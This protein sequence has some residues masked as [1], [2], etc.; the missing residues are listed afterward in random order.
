VLRTTRAIPYLLALVVGVVVVGWLIPVADVV[1]AHPFDRAFDGDRAASVIGQR[2]F[3][4]APWH[5][6]L[7]LA[8]RLGWPSG[9][10]VAFT[11]SIPLALLPLKLIAGWLPHGFYVQEGWLALAW[12]LQPVAAVFALRGTG[13]RRVT[14]CLA[15][16]VLSLCMPAL[17]SRYGSMALCTHAIILGAIGLYF[18]LAANPGPRLWCGAWLLLLAGLLVHP[19]LLVM[20]AA[21]LGAVP[22]TL[23]LRGDQSWRAAACWLFAAAVLTGGAGMVLGYGG[24]IPAEGFGR[25]SMNLLSPFVPTVPGLFGYHSPDPTGGQVDEGN[26][27]LGSGVLLLCFIGLVQVLRGRPVAIR[28][29]LGLVV[30]LGILTVFSLSNRVYAGSYLLLQ[31]NSVP[32]A[33]QQFRATGR[34]FWPAAYVLLI[35]GV[36]VTARTL[37]PRTALLVFL[38][39]IGLQVAETWSYRNAIWYSARVF[40]IWQIDPVQLRPILARHDLLTIW[41]SFNCGA[42]TSGGDARFMQLL[43]LASETTMRTN[44]MYVARTSSALDCDAASTLG[45]PWRPHEV[46]AILPP[47]NPGDR[48]LV[49]D[50][51]KACRT[52]GALVL[53]APD[54]PDVQALPTA[55]APEVPLGSLVPSGSALGRAMLGEGWSVAGNDGVW[56]D[57][58][59]AA[60]RFRLPPGSPATVAI[61]LQAHAIAAGASEHQTVRLL[62]NG[63]A[64]AVWSIPEFTAATLQAVIPVYD[65]MV[66]ELQVQQPVRPA[67]R[68]LNMDR[69]L[70]GVHLNAV[71]M[72]PA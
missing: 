5:W 37:R 41:P 42:P 2:Y 35:A 6:P 67:D 28:R 53:C 57:G 70:L 48:W 29:H 43:L 17:L 24:S 32:V 58:A 71:R 26:Q 61:T 47:A 23:L 36:V 27:Y 49:P 62:V 66:L 68:G 4:A 13:E 18:R 46:R 39:A 20:G 64:A 31:I 50:S 55:E 14:A 33:V 9:V 40:S 12:G 54:D 25:Y 1:P 11:D 52:A 51:G 63:T 60:L 44:T 69:R 8:N 21:V 65:S 16:A 30:I 59:R 15:V 45:A 38:A 10:N 7:L 19:Y 22:L 34:F 3:L 72:D 56:T